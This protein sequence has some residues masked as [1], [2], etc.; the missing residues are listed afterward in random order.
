[1]QRV[2]PPP[3]SILVKKRCEP[4]LDQHHSR[5][6]MHDIR[7]LNVRRMQHDLVCHYTQLGAGKNYS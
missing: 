3:L 6:R 4:I 1:M 5:Q 2:I 7:N